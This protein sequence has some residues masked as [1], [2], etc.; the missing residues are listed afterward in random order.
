M[1][2]PDLLAALLANPTSWLPVLRAVQSDPTLAAQSLPRVRAWSILHF[3]AW[4]AK[5]AYAALLLARGANPSARDAH[6]N[7][8]LHVAAA[9]DAPAMLLHALAQQPASIEARDEA[10]RTPVRGAARP[11]WAER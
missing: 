5:P 4:D 1:P 8:P 11:V 2:P 3:A 7:T 10:D 6:G 9:R